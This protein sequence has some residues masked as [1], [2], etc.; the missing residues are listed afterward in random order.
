MRHFRY[1]DEGFCDTGIY[2]RLRVFDCVRET[3]CGYWIEEPTDHDSKRRWV[4]KTAGKRYAYPTLTLA[5]YSYRRRKFKQLCHKER[6]LARAQTI[7]AWLDGQGRTPPVPLP[8]ANFHQTNDVR[9]HAANNTLE[10]F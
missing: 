10:P 6:E 1:E 7:N 9:I 5:W 2:L 3:P 8:S 4:S